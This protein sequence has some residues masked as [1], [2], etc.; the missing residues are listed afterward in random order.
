LACPVASSIASYAD[1]CL[2]SIGNPVE[3]AILLQRART[4][5]DWE[6]ASLYSVAFQ[7][8][9]LNPTEKGIEDA[10]RKLL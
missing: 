6:F 9:E 2:T 1:C 4:K 5:L 8:N 3:V 7:W 10:E